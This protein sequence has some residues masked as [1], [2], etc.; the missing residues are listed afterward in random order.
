MRTSKRTKGEPEKSRG[1]GKGRETKER[2]RERYN[3]RYQ[4]R[5]T[6]GE[7]ENQ[8]NEGKKMRGR[9]RKRRNGLGQTTLSQVETL[10]PIVVRALTWVGTMVPL[11]P[12]A[13]ARHR[14]ASCL[15]RG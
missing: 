11:A 14:S 5:D 13:A 10:T 9:K 3:E 12:V 6:K 1:K 4:T 15:L 8:G 7:K 2:K